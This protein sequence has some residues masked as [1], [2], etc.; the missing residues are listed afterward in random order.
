LRPI[1]SIAVAILA[2]LVA[3]Q[4]WLRFDYLIGVYPERQTELE[5]AYTNFWMLCMAV[6]WV[7]VTKGIMGYTKGKRGD[8]HLAQFFYGLAITNLAD[9]LFL[10]PLEI[11]GAEYVG[12]G[13][14]AYLAL[15][16]YWNVAPIE[17][18]FK[19]IYKQLKNLLSKLWS[20]KA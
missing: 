7:M 9:E 17:N 16:N 10:S 13:I 5:I 20:H 15:T 12:F 2:T 11:T 14:S 18:G 1:L 6:A 19:W 8:Y 4:S 3:Y